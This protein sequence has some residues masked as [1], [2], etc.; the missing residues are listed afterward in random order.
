MAKKI[1]SQILLYIH[2]YDETNDEYSFKI[3]CIHIH[4]TLSHEL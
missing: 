2:I 4:F 3:I 1:N